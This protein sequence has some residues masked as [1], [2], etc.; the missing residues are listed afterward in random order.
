MQLIYPLPVCVCAVCLWGILTLVLCVPFVINDTFSL[1]FLASYMVQF[2]QQITKN[3]LV[4]GLCCNNWSTLKYCTFKTPLFTHCKPMSSSL[5][6]FS[7]VFHI[8]PGVCWAPLHP[9][10]KEAM[11]LIWGIHPEHLLFINTP[12]WS[13][14]L[15]QSLFLINTRCSGSTWCT[16]SLLYE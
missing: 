14:S 1:V 2:K 3:L 4:M 15:S 12:L 16:I 11:S 13:T 10:Q 6:M 8:Q 7:E 5:C 9:E